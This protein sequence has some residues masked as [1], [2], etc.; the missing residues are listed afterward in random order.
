MALIS[1]VCK[2]NSGTWYLLT[3]KNNKLNISVETLIKKKKHVKVYK[4]NIN[5]FWHFC[6]VF[7]YFCTSKCSNLM[8][9]NVAVSAPVLV[10]RPPGWYFQAF[11][12]TQPFPQLYSERACTVSLAHSVATCS[13]SLQSENYYLQTMDC[14]LILQKLDVVPV[15]FSG[16][17]LALTAA[18]YCSHRIF[19]TA[20]VRKEK[21]VLTSSFQRWLLNLKKMF[22]QCSY[23]NAL[24]HFS[25]IMT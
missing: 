21:E 16:K 6:S 10:M 20:P 2:R 9:L 25:I 8:P 14:S 3:I 7:L 23:M 1:V 17:Q 22:H 15:Q 18:S 11:L 24:L 19:I 13:H 5:D 4:F 12:H